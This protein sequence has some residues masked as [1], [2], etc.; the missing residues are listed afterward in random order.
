[1]SGFKDIPHD[2][3]RKMLDAYEKAGY[4]AQDRAAED[5]ARNLAPKQFKQDPLP[6]M[7]TYSDYDKPKSNEKWLREDNVPADDH[8]VSINMSHKGALGFARD[9]GVVKNVFHLEKEGR[10][11]ERSPGYLRNRRQLE[12]VAFGIHPSA[13]G[14]KRP[15]YGHLR[16]S[17]DYGSAGSMYGDVGLDLWP[18]SHHLTTTRGDSLN[19]Y[20]DARE[21]ENGY[22]DE[23]TPLDKYTATEAIGLEDLDKTHKADD[24][25]EYREV[26]VH[27]GPVRPKDV[28]RASI[29]T[30]QGYDEFSKKQNA[31]KVDETAKHLRRAG[32]PV[33]MLDRRDY[34][35]TIP[36]M[37]KQFD[38]YRGLTTQPVVKG[39]PHYKPDPEQG[40]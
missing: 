36:N 1:M 4:G 21:A 28:Q 39:G 2:R 31:D 22:S 3:V 12:N 35:P 16:E 17:H 34:Q 7:G 37:G 29:M 19:D 30:G 14:D 6:G 10:N 27:G 9:T 13:G 11:D 38:R 25:Y 24:S 18:G 5:Q 33:T 40:W 15:T 8:T 23:R 32:I 26:Q 20:M